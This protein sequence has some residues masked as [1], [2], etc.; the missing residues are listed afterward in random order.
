MG[1]AKR[2]MSDSKA[3]LTPSQGKRE[4]RRL[5]GSIINYI[6]IRRKVLLGCWG[7]LEP[8]SALS[9]GVPGTSLS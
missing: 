8:K 1:K 7:V 6:S 9:V 3:C 2:A 5:G 4:K